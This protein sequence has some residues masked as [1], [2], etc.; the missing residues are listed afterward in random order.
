MLRLLSYE[1]FRDPEE[2]VAE[3]R[4]LQAC[5]SSDGVRHL[6]QDFRRSNLQACPLQSF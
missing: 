4:H 2:V 1:R 6:I 3:N 5:S